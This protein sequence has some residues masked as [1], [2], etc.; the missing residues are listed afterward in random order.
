MNVFE[1][2]SNTTAEALTCCRKKIFM[3]KRKSS[4]LYR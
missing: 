4:N 1:A 2:A 3:L